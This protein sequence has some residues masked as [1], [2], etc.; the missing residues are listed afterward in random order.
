M[1]ARVAVF[2]GF[3]RHTVSFAVAQ[4]R[5]EE[6][7]DALMLNSALACVKRAGRNCVELALQ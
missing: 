4:T 6:S 2:P 7:A 3:D 1:F 5:G